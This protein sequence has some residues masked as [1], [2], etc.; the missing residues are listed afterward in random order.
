VIGRQQAVGMP[1]PDGSAP[2]PATAEVLDH[3]LFFAR[4]TAVGEGRLGEPP[5]LYSSRLGWRITGEKAR[6]PGRSI[7]D[8]LLERLAE[9]EGAEPDPDA[10]DDAANDG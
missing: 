6:E 5:L 8:R 3:E 4:V 9:L 2:D 1:G 10:N 7:R